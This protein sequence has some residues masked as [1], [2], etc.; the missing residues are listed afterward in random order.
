MICYNFHCLC[1]F[2]FYFFPQSIVGLNDPRGHRLPLPEKQVCAG[3]IHVSTMGPQP[4]SLQ[5]AQLSGPPSDASMYSHAQFQPGF[6]TPRHSGPPMRQAETSE[7]PPSHLYRPYKYINQAHP[8]VWNGNHDGANQVA[9]GVEKKLPMGPRALSHMMDPRALRPHLPPSQWTE[10]SNFLPHGVP[11][12]GYIRQPGKTTVQRMQQ[13]L[14]ASIFGPP[15]QLQRGGQGG[16]SMMDSPEMI[17]MQQ[18]SSRVCPPGVPYHPR[19]PPPPHLPGPFPQL[20]HVAS[21]DS[22]PPKQVLGNGNSQD[23]I[24]TRDLEN[25]GN[26]MPLLR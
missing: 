26:Y 17:A 10:Q 7:L 5:L 25:R 8:A 18:L 13:Q 23:G 20:A 6:L 3:P 19:Q 12:S 2:T 14:P 22:Q 21:T 11:S 15:H 4:R 9:L 24:Q 16:D 1:L